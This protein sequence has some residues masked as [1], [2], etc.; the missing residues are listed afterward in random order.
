MRGVR[1][2]VKSIQAREALHL[3]ARLALGSAFIIAAVSKLP[4]PLEL[5]EAI[6]AY[7]LLPAPLIAPAALI[8]PFVELW[9]ALAASFGNEAFRKAGA[10]ILLALLAI[11]MAA[12]IQGLAR[13]LDFDCGCFG[14]SSGREPGALFFIEDGLLALAAA[15]LLFHNRKDRNR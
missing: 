14:A 7:R 4:R 2:I 3:L 13:G 12:A 5:A 15:F 8:L 9:A 6:A 1:A 10:L 11:F